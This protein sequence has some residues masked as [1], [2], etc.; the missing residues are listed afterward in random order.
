[1]NRTAS[2]RDCFSGPLHG[3]G[4]TRVA[5]CLVI[6][7]PLIAC[8]S[9]PADEP[10]RSVNFAQL[11][12]AAS[13]VPPPEAAA[14]SDV[15]SRP[16]A[17]PRP[18]LQTNGSGRRDGQG[19]SLGETCHWST[20]DLSEISTDPTYGYSR[21][22]SIKVGGPVGGPAAQRHY[23]RALRGPRGETIAFERTGSGAQLDV[24]GVP[25]EGILDTYRITYPGQ[26]APVELFLNMYECGL[27]RI[28]VGFTPAPKS[29]PT[30][31][32]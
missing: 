29:Q 13:S 20:A 4:M 30:G 7:V 21:S 9:A 5:Q 24:N 12:E 14:A 17:T 8:G 10:A 3:R 27:L 19:P 16:S 6:L 26:T 15:T 2:S 22:N 18:G 25:C 23:L 11:P 1:M 31:H 32:K 28:P